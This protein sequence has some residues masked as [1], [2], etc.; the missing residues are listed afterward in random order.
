MLAL[1]K[2]EAE[3]LARV[4]D[5]VV[6]AEPFEPALLLLG[7][8]V[9]GGS[10]V[11]EFRVRVHGRHDLGREHR[12]AS[13]GILEGGVGVPQAI[14]EPVHAPAIVGAHDLP[15]LVEIRNVPERLVAQAILLQRADPQLGV[16]LAV[17]APGKRELLVVGEGLV[18]EHED[19]VLVHSRPDLAQGLG[20]VDPAEIDRARLGREARVK[21]PKCQGH[22]AP[23]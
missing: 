21:L 17:Q 4:G 6:D 15:A 13:R 14:A 1:R 18:P 10:R 12:V 3:G 7:Q 16:E 19:G 9:V 2:L 11:G 23:S 20:I 22:W 5:G 8:R